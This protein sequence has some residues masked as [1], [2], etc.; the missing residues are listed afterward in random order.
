[1]NIIS[2]EPGMF[3][4][5]ARRKKLEKANFRQGASEGCNCFQQ[6]PP[7]C[8]ID[9]SGALITSAGAEHGTDF[10]VRVLTSGL[11]LLSAKLIAAES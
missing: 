11:A 7:E 10:R 6:Y 5:L 3:L 4:N 9:P 2:V 8:R 1:M